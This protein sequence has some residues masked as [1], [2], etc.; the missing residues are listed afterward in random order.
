MSTRFRWKP[1]FHVPN[2]AVS[3][4]VR[5]D[6]LPVMQWFRANLKAGARLAIFTLAVQIALSFGHVHLGD[7]R[8]TVGGFAA[9]GTQSAPSAPTQQPISDA[10]EY[11]AI[12]ATIHLTATSLL[13][14][15]PQLPVPLA[16][17]PVEPVNYT[18]AISCSTRRAPFQSRAPPLA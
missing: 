13:P 5:H 1:T 14:Q 18:V 15:A 12:C 6:E 10:D 7:F 11:C 2:C 17:W 9:A 16:T 3:F 4:R 8:H